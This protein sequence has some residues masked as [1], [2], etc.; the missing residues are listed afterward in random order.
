MLK[1]LEDKMEHENDKWLEEQ[2]K[3]EPK[4]TDND[5][6]NRVMDQV[7][8]THSH[9]GTKRKV[10]L[11]STYLIAIVTFALVTPWQWLSAK[12]SFAR[13]DLL[14][15]FT[16]GAEMQVP[17]MALSVIFIVSFFGVVI[18]IEQK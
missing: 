9:A 1:M 3:S 12:L 18:G 8:E 15:N 6:V 7:E 17:I 16:A 2:L 10:I 13:M 11:F 14:N 4:V 5:F